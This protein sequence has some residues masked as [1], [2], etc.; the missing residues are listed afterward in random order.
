MKGRLSFDEEEQDREKS[1]AHQL[2]TERA[3]GEERMKKGSLILTTMCVCACA[4]MVMTTVNQVLMDES[5][6]GWLSGADAGMSGRARV[7]D[8]KQITSKK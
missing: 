1:E 7:T 5:Q 3:N 4:E 6:R 8:K 2:R